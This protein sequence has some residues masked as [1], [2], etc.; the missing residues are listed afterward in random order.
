M[1]NSF[2]R[3]KSRLEGLRPAVRRR[4]L[5]TISFG[6]LPIQRIN[7]R[8][9]GLAAL[10]RQSAVADWGLVVREL[11]RRA[12]SNARW[13]GVASAVQSA[14][15]DCRPQGLPAANLFAGQRRILISRCAVR[16]GGLPAERSVASLPRFQSLGGLRNFGMLVKYELA[17]KTTIISSAALNALKEALVH[18]YWFKADLRGFLTN[19]IESTELRVLTGTIPNAILYLP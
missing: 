3:L 9:G 19:T 17:M 4:G 6:S 7:S 16:G 12:I 13:S 1:R 18:I 11:L 2:Q 8:Q 10:D 14:T 5:D 15:A